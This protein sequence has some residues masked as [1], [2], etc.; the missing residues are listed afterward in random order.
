MHRRHRMSNCERLEV[1]CLLAAP[2]PLSLSS[3]DGAT[4]FGLDRVAVLDQSDRAVSS[5]GDVNGDG[6]DDLLIA[7]YPMFDKRRWRFWR[8]SLFPKLETRMFRKT[9]VATG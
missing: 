6:Y 4:G 7:L 9:I 8:N 3:L 2:P 5:A 1:R